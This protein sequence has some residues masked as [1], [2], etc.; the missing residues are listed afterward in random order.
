MMLLMLI[1]SLVERVLNWLQH[2]AL[3]LHSGLVV[4]VQSL[5]VR[6]L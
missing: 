2:Q 3:L 5:P 1:Q 4:G 6:L